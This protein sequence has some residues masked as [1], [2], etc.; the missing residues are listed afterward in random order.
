MKKILVLVLA[1]Y[2]LS[3]AAYAQDDNIRRPALGISF[4]MNDFLTPQRIKASNVAGV[5]RDKQ[6]ARLKEM[7]AGLSVNYFKGLKKY[8][9]FGATLSGSFLRYPLPNKTIFNDHFLLEADASLHLKMVPEKYWFQPYISVGVGV[10]KYQQYYGAIVPVGVGLK[11]NLFDE[12]YIF[13]NSQYRLPVTNET[14]AHHFYNSLGVA[15]VIGKKKEEKV[16]PPPPPPLPP[17]PPPDPDADGITDDKDKCPAV[18]GLP[19]YDGC[20]APDTDK[21]GINDEEDKCVTV[22]GVA[23][24]QGCPVPDTDKDGI[25]DEED[26]CPSVPGVA[27]YQGCPVP[28]TDGDTVND[29]EDKCPAVPGTVANQGCPEVSKEII[30]RTTY[31]AKNIFFET[32]KATLLS[33]SFAPLNEV[34]K[35]MKDNPELKLDIDGHTDNTGTDEFNQ[36]LSDR[37]AAAVKAYLV[38]RGVDES[39]ITST[40]YGESQPVADNKTSTGR[41]KN[42]RVELKPSY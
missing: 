19:K 36:S 25:N 32:G 41:Q 22:P 14:T 20:P 5:L 30:T 27:R 11:L 31:A 34:A 17:P 42:R 6:W 40:G 18:K 4:F 3:P 28:D 1:V 13:L 33:K 26:K 35:I 29:E 24:Y 23:R 21:D 8:I 16:I 10:S 2:V 7:S 37:R 15:G 9:D 39:R 12:A 38:K